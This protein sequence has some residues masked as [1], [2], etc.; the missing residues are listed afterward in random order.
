[1]ELVKIK[2][3]IWDFDGTLV[4]TYPVMADSFLKAVIEL[5]ISASYEDVYRNLKV[6]LSEAIE[7]YSKGDENLKQNIREG[8]EQYEA[9]TSP[10][11]YKPFD[12]TLTALTALKNKGIRHFILTHRNATTHQILKA[13]G[14]QDYFVD[15]VISDDGFKR[16]PD[17]EAFTYL[18]EK[19]GLNRAE[20]LS[21][22]DRLFDVE[23]GKNAGIKGCLIL[24]A[25]N[26]HLCDQVDYTTKNRGEIVDLPIYDE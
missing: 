26:G 1:M 6:S 9:M 11:V 5:G 3:M 24:D 18:I 13:N 20:T 17:P 4:D 25:Y 7:I 2:N 15:L 16:K 22:G 19:H 14:L 12:D 23:A 10:D 8:F 21:V